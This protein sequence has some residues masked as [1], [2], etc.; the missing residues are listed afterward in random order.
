MATTIDS[1]NQKDTAHKGR[2][3]QEE[4]KKRHKICYKL[5]RKTKRFRNYDNFCIKYKQALAKENINVP[6]SSIL[7][8]DVN[9]ACQLLREDG[10]FIDPLMKGKST[11]FQEF[12][13]KHKG[14]IK[15]AYLSING[16]EYI[17][18][19][20]RGKH[21]YLRK[22]A[23]FQSLLD[24]TPLPAKESS[25]NSE[26]SCYPIGHLYIIL[27]E[28]G[29]EASI[30]ELFMKYRKNQILYVA[31]HRLCSEIVFDTRNCKRIFRAAYELFKSVTIWKFK[32][33]TKTTNENEPQE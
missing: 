10:I 31:N 24:Q 9:A 21:D 16:C 30:S 22:Y 3:S 19:S 33:K 6:T 25:E 29:L 1:G 4:V 14:E 8:S 15:K 27:Y 18:Y 5:L 20:K 17:L 11:A 12:G 23:N 2:N 13:E 28:E 7:Y 26:N 32:K